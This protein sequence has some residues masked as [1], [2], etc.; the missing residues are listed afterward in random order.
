MA[1][2]EAAYSEP[3]HT[4]LPYGMRE[5]A[6]GHEAL[7]RQRFDTVNGSVANIW[8]VLG[9]AAMVV[10]SLLAWSLKLNVDQVNKQSE[11]LQ[12]VYTVSRQVQTVQQTAVVPNP[13]IPR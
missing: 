11:L 8:R 1:R 4:S 2:G 12:A 6:K 3:D 5:W 9:A 10:V 7:D 13:P